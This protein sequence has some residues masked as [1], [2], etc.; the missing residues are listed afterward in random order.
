M[1]MRNRLLLSLL[2][3][4]AV[5]CQAG[6]GGHYF[7]NV[8]FGASTCTPPSGSGPTSGGGGG[9]GGGGS[10]PTAFA[11]AVDQGGTVDGFVLSSGAGTFAAISGFNAPAIPTNDPGVGMVV[12][13]EQFVYAMFGLENQ[14]YGWSLNSSTGAL[15]AL[16]NFPQTLTF[17][18]PTVG[19]NEYSIATNPAGTLLFIAETGANQILAYQIGTDGSLSAVGS[20]VTT[21]VEPGNLAT[22]GL[23]KYLYVT[24]YS[25]A[26]QGGEILAYSIGSGTSIG[27]LTAVPGSPFIFPMWQVQG[28]PSG[29]YLVGTTGS[30]AFLGIPDDTH[31]Y[32]FSITQSGTNAGAISEVGSPV[33]TTYSPFNIAVQPTGTS[34]LVYSFSVNDTDTGYNPVEGFALDSTTGVLTTLSGSPFTNV[35]TGH[36]GQFDQSGALLFVYSSATN[37]TTIETQIAPLNVDSS[38]NL[39]QPVSSLTLASPG[40]WVVT[41]P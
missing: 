25:S 41:D 39:T 31:L 20:P 33:V 9:G 7:C 10:S 23:G 38:G 14:I 22:D 21:P 29:N 26:H 11:Y 30:W 18:L 35:G 5:M 13:Q 3:V 16:S 1:M 34:E 6:C 15:T 8:E 32:V 19:Y 4:A 24:E 28:D 17:D 37:G 40:Y 36:W 12:A 27:V 2:A